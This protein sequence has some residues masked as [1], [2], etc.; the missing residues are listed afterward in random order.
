M[1]TSKGDSPGRE[2]AANEAT[3]PIVY[4]NTGERGEHGFESMY[5][6]FPTDLDVPTLPGSSRD[7]NGPSSTGFRGLR[8]RAPII[9]SV[10]PPLSVPV[11]SLTFPEAL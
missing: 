11:P 7:S 4:Y 8:S 2:K 3:E 9:L 10:P 6:A 1:Q 5:K